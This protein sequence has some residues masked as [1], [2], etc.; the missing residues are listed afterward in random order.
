M[1]EAI[2]NSYQKGDTL[3]WSKPIERF[4]PRVIEDDIK[5]AVLWFEDITG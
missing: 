3:V 5:R 2:I 1:K 4:D